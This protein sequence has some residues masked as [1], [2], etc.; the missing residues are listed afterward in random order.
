FDLG[1]GGFDG[2]NDA[3]QDRNDLGPDRS[4]TQPDEFADGMHSA[5]LVESQWRHIADFAVDGTVPPAKPDDAFVG[6]PSSSLKKLADTYCGIPVLLLL[7]LVV[8]PGLLVW[9]FWYHPVLLTLAL[10]IYVLLLKFV[11]TRV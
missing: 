2:F 4:I 1:S 3:G 6:K 5:A 11:I 9:L 10:V 8:L 7:G